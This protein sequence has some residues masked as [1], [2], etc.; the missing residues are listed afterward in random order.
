MIKIEVLENK[1]LKISVDDSVRYFISHLLGDLNEHTSPLTELPIIESRVMKALVESTSDYAYAYF[2]SNDDLTR[3]YGIS[4]GLTSCPVIV[5]RAKLDEIIADYEVGEIDELCPIWGYTNYALY[6]ETDE[7]IDKGE[8][9][10]TYAGTDEER[11]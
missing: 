10:F 5:E 4:A 2:E 1:D 6:L 3:L 7:L 11:V 9:I 8:I